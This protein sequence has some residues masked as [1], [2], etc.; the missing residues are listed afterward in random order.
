MILAYDLLGLRST[1]SNGVTWEVLM[2]RQVRLLIKAFIWIIYWISHVKCSIQANYA[3][4]L[5]LPRC[6]PVKVD[7]WTAWAKRDPDS[8][9]L[10]EIR[11]RNSLVCF[12]STRFS[13]VID[14]I[15]NYSWLGLDTEGVVLL[16][17]SLKIVRIW[18]STMSYQSHVLSL[19]AFDV[20]RRK[21]RII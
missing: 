9:S 5:L 20:P 6:T 2:V 17:L 16:D 3:L 10:C 21:T 12:N 15:F 8:F 11:M 14:S 4:Q 1:A 19:D 7:N 18:Q 13:S